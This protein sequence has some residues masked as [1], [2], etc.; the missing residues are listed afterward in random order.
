M[1]EDSGHVDY[2]LN[3]QPL[4]LLETPYD[5]FLHIGNHLNALKNSFTSDIKNSPISIIGTGGA[6]NFESNNS[7]FIIDKHILV[8]CGFTTFNLLMQRTI[9]E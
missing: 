2:K 4:E 7:S 5:E 9:V 8:D 3:G 1:K 6:F